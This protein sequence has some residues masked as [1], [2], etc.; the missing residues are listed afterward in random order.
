MSAINSSLNESDNR[1]ET[2]YVGINKIRAGRD[3]E[4]RH[5]MKAF[6]STIAA[7]S[8]DLPQIK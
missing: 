5:L 3:S 6:S 4:V 7:V 2:I 1:K 8:N